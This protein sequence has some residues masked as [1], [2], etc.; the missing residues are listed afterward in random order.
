VESDAGRLHLA[1][2]LN[3]NFLLLETKYYPALR[4]FFQV[5][6]TSDDQQVVLQPGR[7]AASN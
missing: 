7:A 6:K 5:V 3:V 4:N 2:Q 1:R